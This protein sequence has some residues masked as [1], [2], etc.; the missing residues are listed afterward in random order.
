[1]LVN[2]SIASV[3]TLLEID[4]SPVGLE[5]RI[6]R[7][8]GLPPGVFAVVALPDQPAEEP[9]TGLV[10]IGGVI[11]GKRA[12]VFQVRT[13][14]GVV[15]AV[16]RPSSRILLGRSGLTIEGIREGDSAIGHTVRVTGGLEPGTNRIIV[17]IAVVGPE[18]E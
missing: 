10:T 3:E 17:D 1:M 8:E 2:A 15:R 16:V 5:V 12:N 6:E 4:G 7:G 9:G 13:E 11:I 18:F 14:R